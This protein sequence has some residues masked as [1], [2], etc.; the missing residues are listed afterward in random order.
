MVQFEILSVVLYRAAATCTWSSLNTEWRQVR[1]RF[2][3]LLKFRLFSFTKGR[4]I[5]GPRV[6]H[7]LAEPLVSIKAYGHVLRD[8]QSLRAGQ[9]VDE[10]RQIRLKRFTFLREERLK[11][12]QALR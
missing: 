6:A 11:L 9:R 8:L 1:W 7:F 5:Q 10:I 4:C 12:N 3:V 2:V